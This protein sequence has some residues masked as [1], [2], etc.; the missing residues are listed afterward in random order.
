MRKKCAT[1]KINLYVL[2]VM[3]NDQIFPSKVCHFQYDHRFPFS[4]E[5]GNIRRCKEV[6][7]QKRIKFGL[8]GYYSFWHLSSCL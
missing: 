1:R 6:H 4:R 5:M 7:L 2:D 8:P 3:K